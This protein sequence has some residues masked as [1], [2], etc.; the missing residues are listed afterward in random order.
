MRVPPSLNVPGRLHDVADQLHR[1]G[2]YIEKTA[3]GYHLL[4]AGFEE[5][6]V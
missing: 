3:D 6:V 1:Q 4:L 5:T 2:V